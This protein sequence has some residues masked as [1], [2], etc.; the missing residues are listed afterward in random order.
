MDVEHLGR[1][2][3]TCHSDRFSVECPKGS[4]KFSGLAAAKEPKLYVA[5][6]QGE[7]I[8]VGITRQPVGTRLRYGWRANGRKGYYGYAWRHEF[9]QVDLDIWCHTNAIDRDCRDVETV[10]AEIV[11]LIRKVGDWPRFQTEIHFRRATDAHRLVAARIASV[12]GIDE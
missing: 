9:P 1:Y 2:R 6:S 7:P 12:Y 4:A 11:Y 10:E 5:S 8:Y 3:I